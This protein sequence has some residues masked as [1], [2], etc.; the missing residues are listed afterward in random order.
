MIADDDLQTDDRA[1]KFHFAEV[2]F[3]ADDHFLL[4]R[5]EHSRARSGILGNH[6]GRV[7]RRKRQGPVDIQRVG[8]VIP[9]TK[10]ADSSF[11]RARRIVGGNGY[12]VA[13]GRMINVCKGI[14]S[15]GAQRNIGEC[16]FVILHCRVI[17][18]IGPFPCHGFVIHPRDNHEKILECVSVL[19]HRRIR[20]GRRGSG[21]ELQHQVPHL[22][23]GRFNPAASGHQQYRRGHQDRYEKTITHL[24][25]SV[26]I[27]SSVDT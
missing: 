10:A 8:G 5:Q 14:D 20:L 19:Q 15:I 21:G 25:Q 11:Y 1:Q 16:E 13:P 2:P 27:T 9:D 17:R 24:N 12:A 6:R 18:P 26:N 7:S 23:V 22:P 4:A 3:H